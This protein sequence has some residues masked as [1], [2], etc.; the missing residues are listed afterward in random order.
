MMAI[1]S[2]I[3]HLVIVMCATKG[4][5]QSTGVL[6][7]VVVSARGFCIRLSQGTAKIGRVFSKGGVTS[8]NSSKFLGPVISPATPVLRKKGQG[9]KPPKV[10]TIPKFKRLSEK[11]EVWDYRKQTWAPHL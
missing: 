3:V 11:F 5:T 9:T 4:G 7:L 8:E 2:L 1:F 6:P 10:I